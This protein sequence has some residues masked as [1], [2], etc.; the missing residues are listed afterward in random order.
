MTEKQQ[1]NERGLSGAIRAQRNANGEKDLTSLNK[2][3]TKSGLWKKLTLERIES[4]RNG[5]TDGSDREILQQMKVAMSDVVEKFW[6]DLVRSAAA[7]IDHSDDPGS[8]S[9]ANDD[10]V[11]R[12]VTNARKLL[13]LHESTMQ[14]ARYR[15]YEQWARVYV[16]DKRIDNL[17]ATISTLGYTHSREIEQQRSRYSKLQYAFDEF[18]KEADQLLDELDRENLLLKAGARKAS[19]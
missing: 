3:L 13:A 14:R 8:A 15:L 16:H 18:Q 11:K 7:R 2:T 10:D 19:R 4:S 9:P 12:E 6:Q 1:S 17:K 5:E